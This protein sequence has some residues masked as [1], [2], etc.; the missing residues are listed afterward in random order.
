MAVRVGID[1][2][3]ECAES[4]VLTACAD[5]L[6]VHVKCECVLARVNL[7]E[8]DSGPAVICDNCAGWEQATVVSV[9][10]HLPAAGPVFVRV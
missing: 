4:A 10:H 5:A 2:N 8:A 3:A 6:P 9:D 7:F 1:G